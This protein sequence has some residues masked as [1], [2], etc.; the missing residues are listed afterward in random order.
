MFAGSDPFSAVAGMMSQQE[1]RYRTMP[2]TRSATPA[3]P[4]LEQSG[5][6]FTPQVAE[7]SKAAWKHKASGFSSVQPL[8][9]LRLSR[10]GDGWYVAHNAVLPG[11]YYGM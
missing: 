7:S 11:V 3:L 2:T 4:T 5:P 6:S 9:S 8:E 10:P 1:G